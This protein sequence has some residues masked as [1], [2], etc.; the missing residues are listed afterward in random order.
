MAGGRSGLEDRALV[1]KIAPSSRSRK[2]FGNCVRGHSCFEVVLV[3]HMSMLGVK[4]LGIKMSDLFHMRKTYELEKSTAPVS[5]SICCML[6]ALSKE[7]AE[8]IK[9]SGQPE[10]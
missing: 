6:P 5:C 10:V 4:C 7:A 9:P 2:L 1:R 8:R 3:L